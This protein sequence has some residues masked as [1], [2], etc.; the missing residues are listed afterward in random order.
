MDWTGLDWTGLDW[1]G[2]DWTYR[3]NTPFTLA[4]KCVVKPDLTE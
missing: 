3:T 2:L 1:T 4:K